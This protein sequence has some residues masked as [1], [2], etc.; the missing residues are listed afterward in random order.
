[1]EDEEKGDSIPGEGSDTHQASVYA[2]VD[3]HS[4]DETAGP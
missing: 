2:S 1:M 4:G 3:N